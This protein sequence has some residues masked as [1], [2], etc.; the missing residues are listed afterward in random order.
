VSDF[1]LSRIH[2]GE[3]TVATQ[4]Y[5]TVTHMPPE[6]LAEGRLSKAADVCEPLPPPSPSLELPSRSRARNASSNVDGTCWN[7]SSEA[8]SCC[9]SSTCGLHQHSCTSSTGYVFFIV[10][11][12]IPGEDVGEKACH[13]YVERALHIYP[14]VTNST[15]NLSP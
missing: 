14:I 8:G 4:T 13:R 9:R 6:L 10:E 2:I 3:K 1:G 7:Q 12:R 11:L 15:R 5:G